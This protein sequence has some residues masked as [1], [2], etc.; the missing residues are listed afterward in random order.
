[1]QAWRIQRL[2]IKK[3]SPEGDI[4]PAG[5]IRVSL[6]HFLKQTSFNAIH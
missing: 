5:F 4:H 6:N 3:R 2:G 1:M